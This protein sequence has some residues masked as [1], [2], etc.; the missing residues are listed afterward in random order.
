M[1]KQMK[2]GDVARY[3]VKPK[4][5]WLVEVV[6]VKRA[7]GHWRYIVKSLGGG[8]EIFTQNLTEKK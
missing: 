4:K 8:D 7:Y 3:E 5:Y 6:S 2:V 1:E